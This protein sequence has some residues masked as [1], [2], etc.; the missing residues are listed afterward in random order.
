MPAV[1]RNAREE[2]ERAD[3]AEKKVKNMRKE[4][5]ETDELLKLAIENGKKNKDLIANISEENKDL[6][7]NLRSMT[8]NFALLEK[9]QT[10]LTNQMNKR[11]SV[12]QVENETQVCAFQERVHKFKEH[13]KKKNSEL[14]ETKILL[15][16]A[17]INIK[18]LNDALENLEQVKES[19]TKEVKKERAYWSARL[20]DYENIDL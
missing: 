9:E 15:K 2:R 8:E 18:A 3:T 20:L 19:L 7:H 12:I 6:K 13:I 5:D 4:K 14:L 11:E 10:K 1:W 16:K 17:N